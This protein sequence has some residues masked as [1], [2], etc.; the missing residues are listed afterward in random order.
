MLI[1]SSLELP[2]KSSSNERPKHVALCYE[3]V[4]QKMILE[5]SKSP[6]ICCGWGEGFKFI[7][8]APGWYGCGGGAYPGI[9]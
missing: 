7:P 9:K 5:L 3:I 2:Q 8:G 1:L 4:I 6:H